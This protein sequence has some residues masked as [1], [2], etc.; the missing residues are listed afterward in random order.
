VQI[1]QTNLTIGMSLRE[2]LAISFRE[3]RK[4]IYAAVI[5]P[6]AA[7]LLLLVLTP[8]YRAETG[9]VIKTGREYI[10]MA[11]GQSSPIG[12]SS[13]LQEEVNTEIQIM[14]SRGVLEKVVNKLGLQNI[15]PG[16]GVGMF[17]AGTVMDT[18]IDRL[19]KSL[20]VEPV[21]LSNVLNVTFEH[22][23]PKVATEVLTAIVDTYQ[24]TH[25]EVYAGDRARSYQQEILREVDELDH[26]EHER[27]TVKIDNGI[28]DIA[29][30][31][32]SLITQRSDAETHLQEAQTRMV[33]LQKRL[34]S[35][36]ASRGGIK[37]KVT[38]AETAKNELEYSQNA[39]TDLRRNE[40]ALLAR[41]AP[42]NPQVEQVRDQIRDVQ[43]H[44]AA[45]N[46]STDGT[47]SDPVAL[48]AQIDQQIVIDET[49]FAPLQAEITE[50]TAQ[51]AKISAELE[52]I[53]KADTALR[54]LTERID[55]V[56]GDV[57]ITREAFEQ[58]RALDDM[59]RAKIVSIS[60]I[61][62][63]ITSE[64]PAKPKKT[65]YLAGG[66]LIG[67]LAAGVVVAI[68]VASNNTF[69]AAESVERQLRL[70]VLV[71]VPREAGLKGGFIAG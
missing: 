66:L 13:T 55:A 61:Q 25:L 37:P 50:Y 2:L 41:Y 1:H 47:K 53:E 58:A 38:S 30:Q 56:N 26:L 69:V 42:E 43:R 14:T 5:P 6:I 54:V 9:L 44:I 22:E 34:A 32:A 48:S 4:I 68:A 19:A 65:L 8:I 52:R 57:K 46:G 10:A 31:R 51:I 67:L 35:L 17:S 21:K 20:D 18:A 59:D 3:K 45:L 49:E 27:A 71:T 33:T 23:N 11:Q 60:E 15:Y 36:H 62:P 24:A 12:P 7:L 70:P 64:K 28:Y 39:L 29:L 40:T 16:L 63:V